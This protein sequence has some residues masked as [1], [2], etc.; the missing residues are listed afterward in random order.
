[1]RLG[2]IGFGNMGTHLTRKLLR[3]NHECVVLNSSPIAVE[4]LAE[5]NAIITFTLEKFI[6]QLPTP[7]I[8]WITAPEALM[9]QLLSDLT[10]H[11]SVGDIL[12]DG[13]NS[14]YMDDIVR[15]KKLRRKGVHY[16]DCCACGG[17]LGL[18]HGYRLLIGGDRNIV[19]KLTDILNTLSQGKSTA[20]YESVENFR[21]T[22]AA[23]SGYLYCGPNGAGH[24]VKM[25]R[26]ALEYSLMSAYA[27]AMKD[28][29]QV[30]NRLHEESSDVQPGAGFYSLGL[31][32]IAT[33]WNRGSRHLDL[34]VTALLKESEQK[35]FSLSLCGNRFV[36]SPIQA[37]KQKP[38]YC[39]LK[40][41]WRVQPHDLH[42][43]QYSASQEVAAFTEKMLSTMCREYNDFDEAQSDSNMLQRL[44]KHGYQKVCPDYQSVLNQ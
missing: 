36:S 9:D 2:M 11:L 10:P 42:Y 37:A 13:G 28:L 20:G 4:A 7:R 24:F 12:V 19:E 6:Q 16:L 34:M 32:A 15:A 26:N 1:M 5:E 30:K 21:S 29:K 38:A 14:Y 3:G 43:D 44:M 17:Q 41:N 39:G 40:R 23:Q 8:I 33:I 31:R 25:I 27:E 18:L 22:N 35:I